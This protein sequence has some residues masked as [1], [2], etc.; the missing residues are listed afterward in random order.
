[1]LRTRGMRVAVAPF[2]LV[3]LAALASC[4]HAKEDAAAPPPPAAPAAPAWQKTLVPS[5]DL[6]APRGWQT[7]RGVVHFHSPYSH[8]ACDNWWHGPDGTTR[9]AADIDDVWRGCDAQ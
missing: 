3:F 7:A 9:T 5:T 6:G 4:S 1:M 2:S 8:D